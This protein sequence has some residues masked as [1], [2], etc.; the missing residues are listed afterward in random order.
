MAVEGFLAN[1]LD[2]Y[3]GHCGNV[4]THESTCTKK[5]LPNN[6]LIR[7]CFSKIASFKKYLAKKKKKEEVSGNFSKCLL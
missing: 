2:R 5:V 7:R 1:N 4:S 6:Y 3:S